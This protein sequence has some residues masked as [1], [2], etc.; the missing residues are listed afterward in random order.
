MV[1]EGD[2]AAL[3]VALADLVARDGA[4]DLPDVDPADIRVV[5]AA[6]AAWLPAT[7]RTD[8]ARPRARSLP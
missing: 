2:Q 3:V 1:D 6:L 5:H 7:D 8:P 4:L